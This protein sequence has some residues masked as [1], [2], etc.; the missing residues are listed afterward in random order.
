MIL[1]QF[2]LSFENV[3]NEDT[4]FYAIEHESVLEI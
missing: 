2:K 4:E 1:L 3:S